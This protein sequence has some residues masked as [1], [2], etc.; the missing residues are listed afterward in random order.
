MDT[1][2]LHKSTHNKFNHLLFNDCSISYLIYELLTSYRLISILT[3]V[4]NVYTVT[5]IDLVD[6]QPVVI[7]TFDDVIR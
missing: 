2:Y 3:L 4:R 6:R 7:E 1:F 5:E